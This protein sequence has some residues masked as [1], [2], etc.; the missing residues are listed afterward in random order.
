M[1]IKRIFARMRFKSLGATGRILNLQLGYLLPLLILLGAQVSESKAQG[2]FFWSQQQKVPESY[3]STEEPPYLI[4]DMNHT[5]HAFN[6][7][8]LDPTDDSSTE[9]VFYRQWTLNNGW[10]FPNDII[11]NSD[12]SNL[13]L[14]G[15]AYDA[16][17]QVHLIIQMNANV[18]YVKNYLTSAGK[19]ISWPTLTHV[20]R[21]SEISRAG[22]ENVAAIAVT[23][24]G[25]GIVIIYSGSQNGNGLY[26]TSS[27]DAGN[28][29]TDPYPAYLTDDETIIVT[30]PKLYI[31]ESGL[32][33]TVWTSFLK[34]GAGGPGYYANFD[35]A[36][37]IWSEPMA[38]DAPGI[39]TPS[40]IETQ[41]SVF[42]SYHHISTNGNW[43]RRSTDAGKTWS[44]PQQV[45]SR[46]VGTNGAISF[47]VD[48]ANVLHAF[49]GA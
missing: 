49:F 21:S 33:H 17:G 15:A 48:G 36:T 30:D 27:S 43:W 34:S 41:G 18:Y 32:F 24:D 2:A 9:A 37:K 12:G 25:N 28:S 3:P 29:W 19:A 46:H 20:G 4:A 14:L 40:V 45:S 42:V 22:V 16:T 7:Q 23:P 35:P 13:D 5:V 47:A 1:M 11:F 38:L 31:G 26:A 44:A 8:P 10:T 39:R 6:S